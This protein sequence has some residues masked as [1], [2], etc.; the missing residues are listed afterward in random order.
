[1]N[2]NC[3]IGYTLH[4]RDLIF[5]YSVVEGQ[6]NTFEKYKVRRA[7]IHGFTM[8]QS[9]HQ[10]GYFQGSNVHYVG[11]FYQIEVSFGT[12]IVYY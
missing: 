8:A 2:L 5:R 9:R 1:M 11:A 12:F 6:V 4:Y 7:I 3:H 10:M